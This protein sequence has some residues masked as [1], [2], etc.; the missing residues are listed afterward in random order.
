M[1]PAHPAAGETASAISVPKTPTGCRPSMPP[2]LTASM[3]PSTQ[4]RP[5]QPADQRVA[6]ARREPE[7][8]GEQVPGHSSRQAAADDLGGGGGR[9]ASRCPPI[10][11]A[12]A[13]PSSSGPNML[14]TVARRIA[15]NGLRG[16]GR[17]Q[18]RDRVGGVVQAV[19]DRE[20]EREQDRDRDPE[21]MLRLYVAAR[22]AARVAC[23]A[24]PAAT[25]SADRR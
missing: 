18:R 17:H 19:G 6:R 15:C 25:T 4:R 2:Q 10:V 1:R 12:T 8:P 9:N 13:A 14:K 23:R 21:S 3:P 22:V 16:A 5:H 7:P 20:G 24:E 11:S